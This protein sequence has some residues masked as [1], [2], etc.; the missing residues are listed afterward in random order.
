MVAAVQVPCDSVAWAAVLEIRIKATSPTIEGKTNLR[1]RV[2][3]RFIML[4]L[5]GHGVSPL[6]NRSATRFQGETLGFQRS[7]PGS[8]LSIFDGTAMG[9]KNGKTIQHADDPRQIAG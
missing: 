5:S 1:S 4:F 7:N 8:E 2:L 3:A 6:A 9:L